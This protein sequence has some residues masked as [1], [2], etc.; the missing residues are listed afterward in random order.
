[1]W[2][3]AVNLG[4]DVNTPYM[5][6]NVSI[7]HD[8]TMLY[9]SSDRPRG[10]EDLDIWVSEWDGTQWC[11]PT[12]L[13]PN[14]NTFAPE[15]TRP[16]SRV[17]ALLQNHP[18]PFVN[19]SSVF[20]SLPEVSEATLNIYDITGRLVET[21]VNET[22]QPGIHQVWWDRKA[23]PSGVYF[24]QLKAAEVTETRKMVVLD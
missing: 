18:N 2:G 22:Q 17:A 24:Y 16:T 5:E 6:W 23:N 13:G 10:F 19:S 20:Y 21:L 14:I 7:S 8:G 9:I 12:N 4:P 15:E 3:P 11:P 1:M